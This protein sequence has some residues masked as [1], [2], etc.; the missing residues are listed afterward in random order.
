MIKSVISSLI[1]MVRFGSLLLL[2]FLMAGCLEQDLDVLNSAEAERLLTAGSE[3]IWVTQDTGFQLEMQQ[4]SINRF[5]LAD[6]DGD[7]VSYGT[8]SVTEDIRGNF[9]DSLL[10]DF[11]EVKDTNPLTEI[12]TVSLLTSQYLD[13]QSSIQLLQFTYFE[14]E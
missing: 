2:L 3:K 10:F 5:L 4:A 6:M 12:T 8:W 9:T 13:V 7:S 14:D 1:G 11:S